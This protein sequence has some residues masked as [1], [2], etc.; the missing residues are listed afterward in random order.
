MAEKI[1]CWEMKNFW[2]LST[3]T[4]YFNISK[5]SVLTQIAICKNAG[6]QIVLSKN[7]RFTAEEAKN[8]IP[9]TEKRKKGT[10]M[11]NAWARWVFVLLHASN[12]IMKTGDNSMQRQLY[13]SSIIQV[14]AAL[15]MRSDFHCHK[16]LHHRCS[17]GPRSASS[18]FVFCAK[19]YQKH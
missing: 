11:W 9:R 4:I 14:G 2:T 10:S 6:I 7:N 15:L 12:F 3:L 19:H 8:Y 5:I 16:E 17:G 13:N 18:L 1:S